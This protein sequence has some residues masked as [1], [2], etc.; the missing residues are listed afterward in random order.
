MPALAAAPAPPA[1]PAAVP[2]V[3]GRSERPAAPAPDALVSRMDGFDVLAGTPLFCDLSLA[4]MK[5]FWEVCE[6]RRVG[7][8]EVVFDDGAEGAGLYV[9]REGA[10]NVVKSGEILVQLHP[11]EFFGEMS[12]IDLSARTSA[13]I[14]AA[15]DGE[16]FFLGRNAFNRIIAASDGTAL[17]MYRVFVGTICGRL[18]RVS[19]DLAALR[20]GTASIEAPDA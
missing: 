20:S 17:K 7:A 10:F 12:L 9:I 2:P 16:L 14:E 18:R 4:E 19:D 5:R 11:G 13:R 15:S 1:R 8:G 3:A 6:M